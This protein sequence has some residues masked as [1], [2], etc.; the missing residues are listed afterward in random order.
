MNMSGPEGY[1]FNENIDTVRL[2]KISTSSARAFA[3]SVEECGKGARMWKFDLK[4]T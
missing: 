4:D 2:E 1:S 3:Y